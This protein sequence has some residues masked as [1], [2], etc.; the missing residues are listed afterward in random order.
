VPF[1]AS[2]FQITLLSSSGTA[3]ATLRFVEMGSS[4]ASQQQSSPSPPPVASRSKMRTNAGRRPS[5][6]DASTSRGCDAPPNETM[7][8][9]L[10]R[11]VAAKIAG[12]SF[13]TS[14]RGCALTELL[15]PCLEGHQD[16]LLLLC[17][18]PDDAHVGTLMA[19]LR[20]PQ[21]L[22]E[23]TGEAQAS[24]ARG[25]STL[26][27]SSP[28]SLSSSTR[29]L[30]HSKASANSDSTRARGHERRQGMELPPTQHSTLAKATA[31]AQQAEDEARRE[32][33]ALGQQAEDEARREAV[34][35]TS[36]S[37]GSLRA[38]PADDSEVPWKTV[39]NQSGS[40]YCTAKALASGHG[41]SRAISSR[42]AA[43]DLE[44]LKKDEQNLLLPC[45]KEKHNSIYQLV[46]ECERIK[47]AITSL[48]KDLM[49]SQLDRHRHPQV[50]QERSLQAIISKLQQDLAKQQVALEEKGNEY[51]ELMAL[52]VGL[53]PS[54]A[55]L[56]KQ[57]EDVQ[58]VV[59][60]AL[61]CS[62]TSAPTR[63]PSECGTHFRQIITDP[64]Q[65]PTSSATRG[66]S[67]CGLAPRQ[68]VADPTFSPAITSQGRTRP[69]SEIATPQ[70]KRSPENASRRIDPSP[71]PMIWPPSSVAKGSQARAVPRL[72]IVD[73]MPKFDVSTQQD[74]LTDGRVPAVAMDNS[75]D[76]ASHSDSPRS[77]KVWCTSGSPLNAV[78]VEPVMSGSAS[79]PA[80][81]R[82]AEVSS[83]THVR[84]SPWDSP[85][86][87]STTSGPARRSVG[88]FQPLQRT[89]V[90]SSSRPPPAAFRSSGSLTAP[91]AQ[92]L[93]ASLRTASPQCREATS[94]PMFSRTS[95]V[96]PDISRVS[97]WENVRP[98]AFP[99]K[100]TDQHGS[101][102]APC[103]GAPVLSS[104]AVLCPSTVRRLSSGSMAL[105]VGGSTAV[106]V[107]TARARSPSITSQRLE[108]SSALGSVSPLATRGR[109]V[110]RSEQGSTLSLT[111][112]RSTCQR[113]SRVLP[114]PVAGS[115]I[116][117]STVL[118]P[119][120]VAL[121]CTRFQLGGSIS[122][123]ST[124]SVPTPF[125][126][127]SVNYIC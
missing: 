124:N 87:S 123:F 38:V 25:S 1:E 97:S 11:V 67:E 125:L 5:N 110:Q 2:C 16:L 84:R 113:S 19:C 102:T 111:P 29:S 15:R 75:S 103:T 42:I 120:E 54:D 99:P 62:I 90:R 22:Q 9:A 24:L 51:S 3:R 55:N 32:A 31:L 56:S 14:C 36:K 61:M 119:A 81:H 93:S 77:R 66:P 40:I 59:A 53:V 89:L 121:N 10:E 27:K 78:Y 105:P 101:I 48:E 126:P 18:R 98:W 6:R 46:L 109:F 127:R 45:I 60:D 13:E 112:Q 122:A 47:A 39:F 69:P 43:I 64:Q 80:F 70:E 115:E 94:S 76:S 34:S 8:A 104:S 30:T 20:L 41:R 114:W 68:L 96:N 85:P 106:L 12:E 50:S 35:A 23:L 37:A 116:L 118:Y 17:A 7:L 63:T 74:A 57:L 73:A 83:P 100:Q 108:H 86:S 117:S 58:R 65:S 107:A 79:V 71:V 28:L 26:E 88:P 72:R 91:I 95:R 92:D 52:C 49:L 44:E 33:T 4:R 82:K 21:L